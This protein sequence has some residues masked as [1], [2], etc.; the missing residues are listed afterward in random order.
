M[1]NKWKDIGSNIIKLEG[2][3]LYVT[4]LDS[5]LYV[6]PMLGNSGHPRLDADKCI[7][8]DELKDPDNQA[9]LDVCNEKYETSFTMNDYGKHMS[10]TEM[11]G[12]V[13][14]QEDMKDGESPGD[15]KKS[16]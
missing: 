1:N 4:Y 6:C 12:H 13:K 16:S 14:Q 3:G 5:N 2:Y 15:S 9:F 10:I 8:W 7:D 11:K